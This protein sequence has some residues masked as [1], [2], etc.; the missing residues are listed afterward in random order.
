MRQLT[1]EASYEALDEAW[2]VT[3]DFPDAGNDLFVRLRLEVQSC[4]VNVV[5]ECRSQTAALDVRHSRSTRERAL[6][7]FFSIQYYS[8]CVLGKKMGFAPVT[9]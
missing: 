4:S 1:V 8:S 2:E 3:L 9:Q 6:F 7:C 5:G